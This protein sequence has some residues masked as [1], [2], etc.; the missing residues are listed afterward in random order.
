MDIK[1]GHG[2]EFDPDEEGQGDSLSA[3]TPEREAALEQI[4]RDGFRAPVALSEPVSLVVGTTQYLVYNLSGRG[5][6]IYLN[7]PREM[8]EG[9]QLQG[10]SLSI[11]GQSFRVDG[12]V[13]HL[14]NDGIHDLCGIELTSIPERCRDAITRYLQQTRN[15]LFIP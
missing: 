15:T 13:K 8:L 5:I 12:V 2:L 11:E 1:F 14:S 10:L 3:M 9:A 7:Q 4:V 6:G